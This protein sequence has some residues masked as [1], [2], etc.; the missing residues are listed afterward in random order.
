VV[1]FLDDVEDERVSG[2]GATSVVKA[3]P[4]GARARVTVDGEE[5]GSVRSGGGSVDASLDGGGLQVVREAVNLEVDLSHSGESGG[6]CAS[7]RHSSQ[8]LSSVG[9]DS[10]RASESGDVQGGVVLGVSGVG[11][12]GHER[13]VGG[14]HSNGNIDSLN[15][16]VKEGIGG[17]TGNVEIVSRGG[18]SGLDQGALNLVVQAVKVEG[19]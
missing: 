3:G 4:D 12:H 19:G 8:V 9:V 13:G 2:R 5:G 17:E 7:G 10:L 16:E 1:N 15:P 6:P 18:D 11:E 14:P